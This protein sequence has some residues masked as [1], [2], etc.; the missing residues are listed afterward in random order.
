MQRHALIDKGESRDKPEAKRGKEM[1][2]KSGP[3]K[4]DVS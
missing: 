2:W 4:R 1:P 3:Q